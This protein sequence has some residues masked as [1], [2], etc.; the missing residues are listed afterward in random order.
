M[1]ETRF[2]AFFVGAKLR[3]LLRVCVYVKHPH[4]IAVASLMSICSIVCIPQG[5]DASSTK[6]GN[7]QARVELADYCRTAAERELGHSLR[8]EE[9][10]H[11]LSLTSIGADRGPCAHKGVDEWRLRDAWGR[12]LVLNE[13]MGVYSLGSDGIDQ[14]GERDDIASWRTPDRSY[15]P[16]PP[17]DLLRALIPP[18]FLL[19]L[20]GVPVWLWWYRRD[21]ERGPS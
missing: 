15:Y 4:R 19:T 21:R 18:A 7:T 1:Q 11:V 16:A 9:W 14:R 8:P 10:P 2:G 5:A 13:G 17:L 6:S 3:E 12:S 20:F